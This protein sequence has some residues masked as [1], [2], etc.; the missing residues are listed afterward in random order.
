MYSRYT[1]IEVAIT[2]RNVYHFFT[3]L[4]SHRQ[5]ISTMKWLSIKL[6]IIYMYLF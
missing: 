5:F 1:T 3:E 6:F 2:R 4:I